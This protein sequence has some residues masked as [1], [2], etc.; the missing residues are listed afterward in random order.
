MRTGI[1]ITLKLSDRR[2]LAG[3]ARD[4][5]ALHKNVWRA[6]TFLL[7][8]NGVGTHGKSAIG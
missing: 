6:E 2:R 8:A 5:N 7:S 4:R 1:S 3:L